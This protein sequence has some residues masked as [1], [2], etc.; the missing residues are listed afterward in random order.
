MSCGALCKHAEHKEK[1]ELCESCLET[2]LERK[3]KQALR[4][5]DVRKALQLFNSAPIA[6]K[7]QAT[8]DALKDLHPKSKSPVGPPTC[9]VSAAPFFSDKVVSEALSTFSPCTL[10]VSLDTAPASYSNVLIQTN[11][12]TL[13]PPSH[14][15]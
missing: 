10:L 4:D 2:D 12:C 6:P 15:T 9:D 7:N 1:T 14:A 13:S 11:L 3:I 5:G 8:V